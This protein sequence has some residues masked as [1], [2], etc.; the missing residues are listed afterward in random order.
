MSTPCGWREPSRN[1]M[2]TC[3]LGSCQ[4]RQASR[5]QRHTGAS[6]GAGRTLE[7]TLDL[8]DA[9]FDAGYS[10]RIDAPLKTCAIAERGCR[11]VDQGNQAFGPRPALYRQFHLQH[12]DRGR[13]DPRISPLGG[14]LAACLLLA[15]S[16]SGAALSIFP[17][18]EG[19]SSPQAA[20]TLSTAELAGRIQAIYPDVEQIRRAP[21]GRITAYWFGS[22]GPQR[23]LSTR[24]GTRHRLR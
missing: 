5:N 7:I 1:I 9:L 10:L 24:D 23:R 12:V 15:L 16:L 4:W 18:L 13:D 8:A 3:R 11:P 19:L 17:A 22:A 14:L 2:T 21:S 6:V 20:A